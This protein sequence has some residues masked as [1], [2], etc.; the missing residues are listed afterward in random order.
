MC[1]SALGKLPNKNMYIEL[2][3]T[4]LTEVIAHLQTELS[5]LRTGRASPALVE[6]VMVEAYGTRQAL[7]AV[8]SINVADARSLSVEPWD[9]SLLK[10]VEEAIRN[11]NLGL[12]PVN[13]GKAVRINLPS[14]TEEN[15]QALVKLMNQRQEDARIKVRQVRDETRKQIIEDE[16]NKII[17]EDERYALQEKLDNLVKDFNEDIKEIGDAKEKEI[18]TI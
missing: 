6:S 5:Q 11:A 2:A 10:A 1:G 13:D 9:K 16:A 14:L 17:A 3:K 18:M 4:S 8:A 15:R 7:K 12:N